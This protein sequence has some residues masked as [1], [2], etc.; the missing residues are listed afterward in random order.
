[1]NTYYR[2]GNKCIGG[3]GDG[4]LPDNPAAIECP[5]PPHGDAVWKGG[6]WVYTEASET[7]QERLTRLLTELERINTEVEELQADIG[8]T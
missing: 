1:M 4:A 5:M 7:P 2:V 6:K 3:F 8:D